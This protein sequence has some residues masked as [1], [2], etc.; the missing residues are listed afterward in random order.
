[1]LIEIKLILFLESA[2]F[3][4]EDERCLIQVT[5]KNLVSQGRIEEAKALLCKDLVVRS[6][7]DKLGEP[8]GK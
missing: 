7:Y 1:L 5:A 2:H 8:C 3:C 4:A 6:V